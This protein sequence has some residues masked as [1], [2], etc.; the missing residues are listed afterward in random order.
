MS[1]FKYIGVSEG[2]CGNRPVILGTRLEP[3]F[4]VEFGSSEDIMDEFNLSMEQIQECYCFAYKSNG[5]DI[6]ENR[7]R[8]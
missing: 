5:G 4:I 6:S 3:K 2:V 7:N 1:E 8:R